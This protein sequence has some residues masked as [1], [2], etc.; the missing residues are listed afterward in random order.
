[1]LCT[2]RRDFVPKPK[3]ESRLLS[4]LVSL[5]E[6]KSLITDGNFSECIPG[7]S[8]PKFPIPLV[9]GAATGLPRGR[10]TALTRKFQNHDTTVHG[11]RLAL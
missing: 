11:A 2:G 5:A 8:S 9:K 10:L 7:I 4:R 6:L 1:M 3:L